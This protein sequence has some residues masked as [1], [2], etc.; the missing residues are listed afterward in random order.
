MTS[1]SM[2]TMNRFMYTKKRVNPSSPCM[3]PT[4]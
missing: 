1:N 2:E 3:Y 4:E